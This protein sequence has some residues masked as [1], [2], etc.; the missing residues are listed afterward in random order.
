MGK[1]EA[2]QLVD[3]M[4]L[5][6][7]PS[8]YRTPVA[9]KS[10]PITSHQAAADAKQTAPTLRARC[11]AALRAAG[12]EGLTDFQLAAQVGSQ[13]TSAGKRRGELVD[14][15]LVVKTDRTRPAPSGSA[16]AVWCAVT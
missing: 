1:W 8:R 9:R 6:Q 14:A 12:D 15:G 7:E 5:W 10:D 13:Q 4:T 2:S 11:L 3:T 16:A